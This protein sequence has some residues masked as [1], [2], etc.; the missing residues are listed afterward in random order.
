MKS[1]RFKHTI[2]Y[3]L[4]LFMLSFAAGCSGKVKVKGKV[5]FPD[6]TPLT[7]GVVVFDSEDGK[8]QVKGPLNDKGEFAPYESK[9]GDAIK[10]GKYKVSIRD[11]HEGGEYVDNG[12]SVPAT[13]TPIIPLIDKKY[14]SYSTSGLTAEVSSSK[15]NVELQV[16]PLN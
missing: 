10:A 8:Y 12:P 4:A 2:I 14:G 9:E 7:K 6:G 15:R 11:A 5:T 13:S 3:V 16:E 1:I